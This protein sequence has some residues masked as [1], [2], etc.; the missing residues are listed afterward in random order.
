[1]IRLELNHGQPFSKG[2]DNRFRVIF[3]INTFL[4]NFKP[5][6]GQAMMVLLEFFLE[7]L[8]F[9]LPIFITFL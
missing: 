8:L 1:M 5:K 7:A 2:R 4:N 9:S 6:L 3:V